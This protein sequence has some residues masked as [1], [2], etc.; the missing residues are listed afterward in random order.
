MQIRTRTKRSKG[1]GL[2][3][4]GGAICLTAML[5]LHKASPEVSLTG[6]G[7]RHEAIEV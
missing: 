5:V 1:F 6:S 4:P 7:E 2:E 3:D